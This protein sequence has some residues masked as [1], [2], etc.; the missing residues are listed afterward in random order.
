ML[1]VVMLIAV[2]LAAVAWAVVVTWIAV[3]LTEL[4]W[5]RRRWQERQRTRTER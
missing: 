5:V 2:M 4:D 3:L 1:A